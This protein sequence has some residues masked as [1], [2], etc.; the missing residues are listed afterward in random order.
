MATQCISSSSPLRFELHLSPTD[1][2]GG[3]HRDFLLELQQDAWA[4]QPLD[5]V[6]ENLRFRARSAWTQYEDRV[7]LERAAAILSLALE[8]AAAAIVDIDT[9][10]L[11]L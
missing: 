6:L 7:R 1:D 8:E 3:E 5:E 11:P 10:E 2:D 4:S 9:I